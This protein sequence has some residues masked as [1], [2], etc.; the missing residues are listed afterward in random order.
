MVAIRITDLDPGPHPDRDMVRRALAEV[1][2][3]PVILVYYGLNTR[4]P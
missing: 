4:I 2:I 1:C 3:D